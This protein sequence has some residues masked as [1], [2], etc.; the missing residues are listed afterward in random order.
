MARALDLA[1]H[2]L[3]NGHTIE[4]SAGTGKTYSIALMAVRLV[5]QKR[6]SLE[7]VLMVTF[8]IAFAVDLPSQPTV[9]KT[10]SPTLPMRFS[11]RCLPTRVI[12]SAMSAIFVAPPSTSTTQQSAPF[13]PSAQRFSPSL[14]W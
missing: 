8:T 4:A 9:W 1:T 12:A 10:T 5:V 11:P 2:E 3:T 7:K 14:A 6:M 13:T